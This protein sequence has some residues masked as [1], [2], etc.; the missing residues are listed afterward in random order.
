M[1][2]PPRRG[3]CELSIEAPVYILEAVA[4]FLAQMGAGGAVFSESRTKEPG[5]ERLTGFLP[6]DQKLNENI[7]KLKAYINELRSLFP[8]AKIS[9]LEVQTIID[10]D[11]FSAWKQTV[12]PTRVSKKFW[13]VPEWR[14]VPEEAKAPEFYV[15][16]MEPGM[17]FGTG[18]HATTQLCL[19]F[20]EELVPEKAKSLLDF[21]T[22][23]GI[24]AIAGAMLG[25]EPVLAVE[26]DPIS[27]E[28]ARENI[29]RNKLEGKIQLLK[30]GAETDKRLSEKNFDL[31]IANLFYQELFRLRDYLFEHLNPDGYLVVSGILP[32]QEDIF[33]FYEK[34]ALKLLEKRKKQGW[35]AGLMRRS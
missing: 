12:V 32:D 21:G 20:I 34:L 30:A 23:T 19:E 2:N 1:T 11:W 18:Y 22:G 3:W 8:Q 5:Y 14:E 31:I 29:K 24:L 28:V 10:Q 27:V 7:A 13:V 35:L 26:I 4:D 15:I 6:Y 33:P 17:A 25:A 9:P 16:R